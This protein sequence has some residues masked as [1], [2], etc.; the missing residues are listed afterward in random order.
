MNGHQAL[1]PRLLFYVFI[2]A[3]AATSACGK[4]DAETSPRDSSAPHYDVGFTNYVEKGDLKA[5]RKHGTIRIVNF[6]GPA[7]DRLPR[8]AIVTQRHFDLAKRFARHL[9]LDAQW[10]QAKSPEEAMRLVAE[11]HADLLADNFTDTEQRRETVDFSVPL[12]QIHQ[13]LVTGPKGPDISAADK[14]HQVTLLVL[15]R[16]TYAETAKAL[17]EQF[18]TA[19]L[20]LKEVSYHDDLDTLLD[21][22]NEKPGLATILDSN[23]IEGMREYRDDLRIGANVSE[24]ENIAWAVRKNSPDLL[25][26]LNNFLTEI[27]V[28]DDEPRISD[29]NAIKESGVLRLI[30]Y[31]S[32]TSYFLWKGQLM[33]FDYD[34]ARAFAEEHGLQLQVIVAPYEVDIIDWL[35]EGRGDIAGSSMTITQ[36]RKDRGVAFSVPYLEMAEQVVSRKGEPAISRLKDLN[37]RTLT[38]RARTIFVQT[39]EALKA[40]GIKV[41]VDVAPPDVPY[42]QILNMIADNELDATIVDAHAAEIETTLR[43]ELLPGMVLGDPRPQ[44]WMV[45]PQNR[46]LLHK[47]NEFLTKFRNSDAYR[48]KIDAYFK[49]DARYLSRIEARVLPGGPLSPFDPLVQHSSREHKFDWRLVTAQMW[50]ESNFNPQAVSPVGAQGLMQVMPR[51]A[52]EM[53]YPPPLFDPERGIRAGIKYLDWVRGRFDPTLPVDNKLWFILA[54]YNAGY[55][56][57][58]DARRLAKELGYDPDVWFGNVEKAMLKLSEPRYFN[59]ARYGYVRGSEPVQYVRNIANLYKAYTG[60]VGGD[61]SVLGG[62]SPNISAIEDSPTTGHE[63]CRTPHPCH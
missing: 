21:L 58:L 40:S 16:S 23:E 63:H 13:Q 35:K 50:Q 26:T 25:L 62:Q 59:K 38:L 15:G 1:I 3:L 44:G 47:V 11:G 4:R 57:L 9:G 17:Q 53:G 8:S 60:V 45:L 41:E 6:S 37:G 24:L 28:R 33:G 39:A 61:V 27:L 49:P 22:V 31:N 12:L 20:E 34:L 46:E 7:E 2:A 30:T 32:A 56:H 19:Q 36:E 18:P 51:T 14:L 42:A 43:D 5:L 10:V 48:K 29:W 54:S 55:G 52:E